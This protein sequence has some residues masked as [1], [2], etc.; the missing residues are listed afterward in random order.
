MVSSIIHSHTFFILLCRYLE[1]KR[2][3]KYQSD[4]I[5]TPPLAILCT[6]NVVFENARK[7]LVMAVRR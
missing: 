4:G 3:E 5:L 1:Q 2:R 6:S 7:S